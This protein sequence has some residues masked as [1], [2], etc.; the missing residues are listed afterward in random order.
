MS[1]VGPRPILVDQEQYYFGNA[2]YALR[3]GITGLWQISERN[4]CAFVDRVIYD[5]LYER[6]VSLTT[7]V[8]TLFRT[9]N[10][11]LRGTGY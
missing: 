1:M 5:D 4:S 11:V 3:P 8:R 2:Y 10:V 7:D 6:T 9:V